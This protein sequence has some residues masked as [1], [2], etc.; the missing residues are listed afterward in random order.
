MVYCNIVH[1][2]II[3][4]V[5]GKYFE[6]LHFFMGVPVSTAYIYLQC[7]LGGTLVPPGIQNPNVV[8]SP[9]IQKKYLLI[10]ISIVESAVM[11]WFS[12]FLFSW[13]TNLA[14]GWFHNYVCQ[15]IENKLHL[16]CI[17]STCAVNIKSP[18]MKNQRKLWFS[19]FQRCPLWLKVNMYTYIS[20]VLYQLPNESLN[21][22]YTL[23]VFRNVL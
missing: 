8:S 2:Y 17:R 10:R 13:K 20:G 5:Y 9:W 23:A 6:L 1:F 4:I 14:E 18:K 7:I 16:F 21:K 15:S 11:C 19:W 3:M 12:I 22:V